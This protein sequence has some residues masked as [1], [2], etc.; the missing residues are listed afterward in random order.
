MYATMGSDVTVTAT[1]TESVYIA[2]YRDGVLLT[3]GYGTSRSLSF[4]TANWFKKYQI[5]VIA[6]PPEY[7]AN[8]KSW[9][10]YICTQ[11]TVPSSQK[12]WYDRTQ[13][14]ARSYGNTYVYDVAYRILDESPTFSINPYDCS[15][16][17]KIIDEFAGFAGKYLNPRWAG[18]DY[19]RTAYETAVLVTTILNGGDPNKQLTMDCTD[20][21]AFLSGMATA[22]GIPSRMLTIDH[23]YGSGTAIEHMAV[24]LYGKFTYNNYANNGWFLIDAGGI[25]IGDGGGSYFITSARYTAADINYLYAPNGEVKILHHIYGMTLFYLNSAW[26]GW[27]MTVTVSA[28]RQ[29]GWLSCQR[30]PYMEAYTTNPWGI[31]L[32]P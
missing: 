29:T 2:I 4:S 1:T 11:V 8:S 26:Y 19:S 23:D 15:D 31:S 10:G 13:D 27:G 21:S 16:V 32:A 30:A 9:R 14:Y 22:V 18:D 20:F 7:P 25:E 17:A 5:D 24:E 28:N 12:V 3:Y 6:R